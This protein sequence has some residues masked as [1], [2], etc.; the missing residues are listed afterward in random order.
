[1][2]RIRRLLSH[3]EEEVCLIFASSVLQQS[4]R[5]TVR[6]NLPL[7]WNGFYPAE[8]VKNPR[9][10][11]MRIGSAAR[12][13]LKA[14]QEMSDLGPK[15]QVLQYC[16]PHGRQTSLQSLLDTTP[17]KRVPVLWDGSAPAPSK[18]RF[19]PPRH[20]AVD[21]AAYMVGRICSRP[22]VPL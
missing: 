14:G 1:M 15:I 8:A 22:R 9:T 4:T 6:V 7:P 12:T 21:P 18:E 10:L 5:L 2:L 19:P 3:R 17:P 20:T 11:P 13:L 16:D